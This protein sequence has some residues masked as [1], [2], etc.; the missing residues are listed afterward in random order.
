[1]K[2]TNSDNQIT[3][4]ASAKVEVINLG[5]DLHAAHVVVAVQLDGCPPQPAQRIATEKYAAWVKQLQEK[6]PAAKIHA[7]YEAGPC[8]YWLHRDL[9][10]LGVKNYVVAPVALNGRRKTDKRDARALGE[11]L[12]RYRRGHGARLPSRGLVPVLRR[13]PRARH[14][15]GPQRRLVHRHRC[16]RRRVQ[17]VH[18]PGHQ[19]G[20]GPDAFLHRQLM[21][22]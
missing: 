4:A 5:Q 18:R 10:Q 6:H 3:N 12:G 20:D 1:M 21:A 22:T 19:V 14:D 16:R 11:Q 8:G 7:C 13:R 2:T 17:E 9:T 15:A